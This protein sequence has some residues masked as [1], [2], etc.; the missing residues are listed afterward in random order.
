MAP[1]SVRADVRRSAN[2]SAASS[3]PHSASATPKAAAEAVGLAEREGPEEGPFSFALSVAASSPDSGAAEDWPLLRVVA[4]TAL[5]ANRSASGTKPFAY[6]GNCCCCCWEGA[7]DREAPWAASSSAAPSAPSP[8]PS[9]PAEGA[10]AEGRGGGV[11]RGGRAVISETRARL[12]LAAEAAL[13]G[14]PLREG[15][16]PVPPAF[17]EPTAER[18]GW[19]APQTS[20]TCAPVGDI[21]HPDS[22]PRCCDEGPPMPIP[23]PPIPAPAADGW[24]PPRM[25]SREKREPPVPVGDAIPPKMPA[26]AASGRIPWPPAPIDG[27]PKMAA[28]EE[29]GGGS[30]TLDEMPIDGNPPLICCALLASAVLLLLLLLIPPPPPPPPNGEVGPA[31]R[32]WPLRMLTE[33]VSGPLCRRAA[34]AASAP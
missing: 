2:A 15:G 27:A 9:S 28:A 19:W 1:A 3:P 31:K 14:P 18:E 16:V 29:T 10:E 13:C 7:E 25:P 4:K 24:A 20:P 32:L 6:E 26:V 30:R 8:P 21:R 22:P 34:E 12:A 23:M 33:P 17:A 11:G 5:R